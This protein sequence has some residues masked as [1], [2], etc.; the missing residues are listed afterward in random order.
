MANRR[1]GLGSWEGRYTTD[2][3]AANDLRQGG[4]GIFYGTNITLGAATTTVRSI[5]NSISGGVAATATIAIGAG[6]MLRVDSIN[7]VATTPAMNVGNILNTGTLPPAT[8]GGD[9]LLVTGLV[10]FFGGIGSPYSSVTAAVV[11][12]AAKSGRAAGIDKS[13][14][15]ARAASVTTSGSASFKNTAT[16]GAA[17]R[18]K[19]TTAP[20]RTSAE[21]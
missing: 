13:S 6:E 11:R 18:R 1:P 19:A 7:A 4:A 3:S 8:A 12:A 20:I 5:L 21:G 15:M 10:Y 2:R 9:L 16:P 14:L 17:M